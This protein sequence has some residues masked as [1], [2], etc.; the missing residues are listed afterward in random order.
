MK[1][2]S[3]DVGDVH[4]FPEGDGAAVAGVFL[5]MVVGL[6]G[7]VVVADHFVMQIFRY[8][9]NVFEDIA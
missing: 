4:C 9:S 2:D 7:Y 8:A 3:I 5:D 1:D 6:E